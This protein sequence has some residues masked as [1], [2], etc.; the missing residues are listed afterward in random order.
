MGFCGKVSNLRGLVPPVRQRR[1]P[2]MRAHLFSLVIIIFSLAPLVSKAQCASSSCSCQDPYDCSSCSG[3]ECLCCCGS[4]LHELIHPV[5]NPLGT[6][7]FSLTGWPWGN[8]TCLT[9]TNFQ[10]STFPSSPRLILTLFQGVATYTDSIFCTGAN[11]NVWFTQNNFTGG[12]EWPIAS[13]VN[14]LINLPLMIPTGYTYISYQNLHQ[15][16]SLTAY[17]VA[18]C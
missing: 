17:L 16:C 1:P 10:I 5:I 12:A 14:Q 4:I 7:F 13:N 6:V 3:S 18:C 8:E 2:T 15:T 11:V 9:S